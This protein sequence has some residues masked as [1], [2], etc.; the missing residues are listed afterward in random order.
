M[1]QK[2]FLSKDIFITIAGIVINEQNKNK[3]LLQAVLGELIARSDEG[4]IANTIKTSAHIQKDLGISSVSY[5]Q[6]MMK[7]KRMNLIVKNKSTMDLH[8]AIR[9][10]FDII[11]IK[12]KPINP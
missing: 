3:S 1:I 5:R 11:V 6:V 7:L 8:P 2:T 4:H 10:P 12:Q 9:P